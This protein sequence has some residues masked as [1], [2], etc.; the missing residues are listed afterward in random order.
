MNAMLLLLSL[1]MCGETTPA[2]HITLGSQ[3]TLRVFQVID[4]E[5]V[6][7]NL[8]TY[9]PVGSSGAST[10]AL[11]RGSKAANRAIIASGRMGVTKKMLWLICPTR[12]MVDDGWGYY[13]GRTFSYEG[14]KTYETH[15]GSSTVPVYKLL[16]PEEAAKH[17]GPAVKDTPKGKKAAKSKAK[18]RPP[19]RR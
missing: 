8:E 9:G 16:T 19:K 1:N 14:T 3:K 18:T 5:N 12:D 4:K 7:V 17:L 10:A 13:E 2:S 15:N 11:T 6:L